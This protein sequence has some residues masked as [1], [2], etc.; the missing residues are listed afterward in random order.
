MSSEI[1]IALLDDHPAIRAGLA[2]VIAPEEDLRLVGV[3]AHEAELWSL[4]RGTRP[5]VVL[6]DLHNP[7]GDALHLCFAL[8]GQVQGPALVLYTGHSD[9]ALLVAA[10]LAGAGAVVSKSSPVSTL[11]DAIRSL[12]RTPH[13]LPPIERRGQRDI[14]ARLD[15]ADPAILA[16]RLAGGS[17]DD[18]GQTLRLPSPTIRDRIAGIIA[19]LEPSGSMV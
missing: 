3:A 13:T 2:A 12:A 16:M 17:T 5:D 15:P 9:D 10:T 18:I 7:G 1:R 14:A 11:L 8:T 19:R 4:V 6:L